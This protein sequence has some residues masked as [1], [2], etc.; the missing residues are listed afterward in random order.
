MKIIELAERYN[1]GRTY[2]YKVLSDM[3]ALRNRVGAGHSYDLD[4]DAGMEAEIAARC[5]EMSARNKEVQDALDRTLLTGER[6]TAAELGERYK[7]DPCTVR[8]W[9]KKYKIQ[10]INAY[11]PYRYAMTKGLDA[12]LS[13]VKGKTE[14]R[15]RQREAAD[16]KAREEM[17]GMDADESWVGKQVQMLNLRGDWI[18]GTLVH[19]NNITARVEANGREYINLL[20]RARLQLI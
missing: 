11:V 10:P 6:L 3:G 8:I 5:A 15:R 4:V 19:I 20:Y 18:V 1:V 7:M 17:V 12:V 2:M 14:A 16:A 9:L 13:S